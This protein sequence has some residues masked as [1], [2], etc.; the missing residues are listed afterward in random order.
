MNRHQI[1]SFY[2][3]AHLINLNLFPVLEHLVT[4]GQSYNVRMRGANFFKVIHLF[5]VRS[6]CKALN[7]TSPA[8]LAPVHRRQSPPQV[9]SLFASPLPSSRVSENLERSVVSS[10]NPDIPQQFRKG[11]VGREGLHC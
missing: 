7:M 2:R 6:H 4:L 11:T 8:N 1:S 10:H 5:Q 9:F 3:D